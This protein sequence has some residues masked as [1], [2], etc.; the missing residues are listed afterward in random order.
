MKHL[1]S[2]I[3][4]TAI[5]NSAL[6]GNLC[7]AGCNL[8]I[9][10]TS[11]GSIEAVEPLT[12]TFGDGGILGLGEG[13]TL[14]VAVPP[15]ST[16]YSAGGSLMLDSGESISFGANAALDL[17]ASGNIEYINM[18]LAVMGDVSISA[19]GG[20]STVVL[21]NG[22]WSV[23]GTLSINSDISVENDTTLAN[24]TVISGSGNVTVSSDASLTLGNGTVISDTGGLTITGLDTDTISV[25]EGS[26][27][28]LTLT[29]E[30]LASLEGVSLKTVDGKTCTVINGECITAQGAKYVV[31]DG[32]LVAAGAD[33]SGRLNLY[34]LL[35]L[36][37]SLSL[38]RHQSVFNMR[39]C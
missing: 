1:I 21:L 32:E 13:G 38:L 25:F 16:D 34:A 12:L 20:T 35:L 27:A 8:V 7:N 10:F 11:G 36:F 4:L 14:N 15:A 39:K 2:I 19:S 30:L 22:I 37:I 29:P 23:D 6:A 9:N 18:N 31:V 24:G 17:G 3:F 5:S 28:A 26:L 33:S